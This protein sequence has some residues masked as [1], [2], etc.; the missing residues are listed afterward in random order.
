VSYKSAKFIFN[1]VRAQKID[2]KLDEVL[3]EERITEMEVRA[4]LDRVFEL[5]NGDVAIG[6]QKAFDSGIMD[7]PLSSNVNT[8]GLVLGVRDLRGACRYL[9]FGNL[10]LPEE[11]K[12]YNREKIAERE[13]TEGKKLDYHT[14]IREFWSFADAKLV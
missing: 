6:L 14:V 5:G 10:P 7:S 2:V 1:V 13:K 3:I 9:D 12:A 11:A 4:I 8:K